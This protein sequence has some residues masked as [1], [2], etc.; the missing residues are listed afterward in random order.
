MV[1]RARDHVRDCC[2][3]R[4]LEWDN[5]IQCR[6]RSSLPPSFAVKVSDINDAPIFKFGNLTVQATEMLLCCTAGG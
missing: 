6:T 3:Q 2:L 5:M 1:N 4:M